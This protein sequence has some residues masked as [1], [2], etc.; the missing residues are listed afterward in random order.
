MKLYFLDLL[1]S[2]SAIY[3]VIYHL[4]QKINVHPILKLLFSF[5]QEAVI[6]F[7]VL[8]G[9]V[10]YYSV[11]EKKEITIKK[12]I[13]SRALRIYP[14]MIFSMMFSYL[15]FTLTNNFSI[16]FPIKSFLN[17]LFMLQDFSTG[18]PGTWVNPFMHNTPLWS[19]SYEWW[20]YMLFIFLYFYLSE[21]LSY[22]VAILTSIIGLG[23]YLIIP[24]QIG[25]WFMYF[26]IWW[27]GVEIAKLYKSTSANNISKRVIYISMTLIVILLVFITIAVKMYYSGLELQFGIYPILFI[28]HFTLALIFGWFLIVFKNKLLQHFNKSNVL[29]LFAPYTYALYVLHY[30]LLEFFIFKNWLNG[31]GV[32]FYV[33]ITFFIAYIVERYLQNFVK[34]RV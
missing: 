31:L 12:Y 14:I 3:V 7:F 4:F 10:I 18:K 6:I 1:R 30:P 13:K 29:V 9:F 5:G 25:L 2:C 19:L 8:S 32:I 28:R 22:W 34:K 33:F 26:I 21:K 15:L 20:F 17:N 11:S 23:L 24:N 16:S 27:F